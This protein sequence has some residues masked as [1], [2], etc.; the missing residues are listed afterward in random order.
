MI[1]K[2][3][4]GNVE[5]VFKFVGEDLVR[6][7]VATEIKND[8]AILKAEDNGG[9]AATVGIEMAVAAPKTEHAVVKFFRTLRSR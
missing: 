7:G 2:M 6:R 8:V 4:N 5:D 3:L 9:A 1:V